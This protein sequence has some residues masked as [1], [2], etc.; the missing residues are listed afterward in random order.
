MRKKKTF[1]AQ[2]SRE[3]FKKQSS[4][5]RTM[6]SSQF[7][8]S[9]EDP[10]I[11]V[12][13]ENLSDRLEVCRIQHAH[14]SKV[15][16]HTEAMMLFHAEDESDTF[17]GRRPASV[18][19]VPVA[20]PTVEPPVVAAIPLDADRNFQEYAADSSYFDAGNIQFECHSES[21]FHELYYSHINPHII[22]IPREI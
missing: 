11:A 17:I 5:F 20:T 1:V 8:G 21:D 13:T 19:A 3:E 2:I 6:A 22:I 14:W 15:L 16:Q 12:K 10:Y 9:A 18:E 4:Q 7:G